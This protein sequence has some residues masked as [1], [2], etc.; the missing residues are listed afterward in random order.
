LP[1][2]LVDLTLWYSQF[3]SH[4]VFL[5]YSQLFFVSQHTKYYHFLALLAIPV[6]LLQ[7]TGCYREFS[8]AANLQTWS[9]LSGVSSVTIVATT[10]AAGGNVGGGH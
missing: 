1:I 2:S 7:S 3:C 10:G 5:I 8:Y 9:V 4:Q 6:F